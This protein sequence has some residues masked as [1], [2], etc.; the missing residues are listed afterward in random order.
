VESVGSIIL[1]LPL[2]CGQIPGD[3]AFFALLLAVMPDAGFC[4]VLI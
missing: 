1:F 2:Q 3:M 4:V